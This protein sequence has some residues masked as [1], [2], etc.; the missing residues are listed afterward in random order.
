MDEG[1][2]FRY[3]AQLRQKYKLVTVNR[4]G[5]TYVAAL[6]PTQLEE[7]AWPAGTDMASNVV[8][9]SVAEATGVIDFSDAT[10]RRIQQSN[11]Y[12]HT[13]VTCDGCAC[14]SFAGL[15]F[16]CQTC[17]DYDL[18]ATCNY[19]QVTT[20]EHR[21]H[22]LMTTIQPPAGSV[23]PVVPP[24]GGGENVS[25]PAPNNTQP[26]GLPVYA[27][28]RVIAT[29]ILKRSGQANVYQGVYTTKSGEASPVAIKVYHHEKDWEDCKDE[30]KA[31]LRIQGHKNVMEVCV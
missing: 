14:S 15:R 26:D 12:V 22:H 21:G 29:S 10:E 24:G 19:N 31:L 27:N 11:G 18:C 23:P 9:P 7:P 30:L 5:S 3:C 28:G 8:L 2:F 4:N 20:K 6:T 13:S 25:P 16:K 17:N 1:I